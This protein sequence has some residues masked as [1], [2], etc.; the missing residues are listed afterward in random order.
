MSMHQQEIQKI[1]RKKIIKPQ[2]FPGDFPRRLRLLRR[3]D[4]QAAPGRLRLGQV[5]GA[6]PAPAGQPAGRGHR[7]MYTGITVQDCKQFP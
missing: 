4:G 6:L 1:S 2:L 5:R 3:P 7:G